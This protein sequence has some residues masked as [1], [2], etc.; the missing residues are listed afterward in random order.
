[1]KKKHN[2]AIW[3]KIS[4]VLSVILI[5]IFGGYFFLDK[6]IIPKYF[7][8]YGI[9]GMG[10]LMGVISSLYKNPKQNE[11]V[12][13]GWS[14][15]DWISASNKLMDADYNINEDGQI[16]IE[17]FKA[18]AK[19]VELTDRE[20]ASVCNKLIDQ[21]FLTDVLPN[22]NYVNLLNI[23]VLE[24]N[25]DPK[26]DSQTDDIYTAAN[27][28]FVAKLVTTDLIVQISNQMET[29]QSLLELIIP[30]ELYFEVSYDFDLEKE[31]EERIEQ[32]L[33]AIN[34]RTAS[35]SEILI[36]MLIDFIFPPEEGMNLHKFTNT[37]GDIILKGIDELGEFKFKIVD[38]R[39]GF[40]I[41]PK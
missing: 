13:N 23:S 2:S 30:K 22:L 5:I 24:V 35:Q 28:N 8:D 38:N 29:P 19:T 15:N 1:M 31:G 37:F 27:I 36:N 4:I 7:G 10:D 32:G 17:G 16:I 14:N 18:D 21:G 41:S 33:I 9:N 34:G 40:L 11:L 39:N 12:S 25:I 6:L 3:G 20:F 26:E